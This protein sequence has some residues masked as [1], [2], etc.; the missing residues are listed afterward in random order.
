MPETALATA[1]TALSLRQLVARV[2]RS[3]GP[4]G[5]PGNVR[6]NRSIVPAD[7]Q[8]PQA[9]LDALAQADQVVLGA[10]RDQRRCA[11]RR[12]LRAAERRAA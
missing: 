1:S 12:D 9:A 3:A 6:A 2:S 11:D 4:S 10:D 5:R 8:A 7:A